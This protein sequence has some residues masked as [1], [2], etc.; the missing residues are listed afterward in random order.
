MP[1]STREIIDQADALAHRFEEHVS[2]LSTPGRRTRSATCVRR[3][4]TGHEPRRSSSLPSSPPGPTTRAGQPSGRCSHFGG[5][6]PASDTD[7]RS[8]RIDLSSRRKTG[9]GWSRARR[10][11]CAGRGGW[12]PPDS[13]ATSA[14]R[15]EHPP[16]GP[17]R[18]Q[19]AQAPRPPRSRGPPRR[20]PRL[21]STPARRSARG[22]GEGERPD[23]ATLSVA[24]H[25]QRGGRGPDDV[26]EVIGLRD[27]RRGG[28]LGH[29]PAH[30][31]HQLGVGDQHLFD[32]DVPVV[33]HWRWSYRPTWAQAGDRRV[34]RAALSGPS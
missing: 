11:P 4:S 32:S 23:D 30:G 12:R 9:R 13:G 18:W 22:R 29:E 25:E 5:G 33:C 15:C 27:R 3:S 8:L 16:P 2:D 24:R 31:P 17:A 20:P 1:R 28:E 34:A 10:N 7:P 21:R 19:P 14:R 26:L 6:G